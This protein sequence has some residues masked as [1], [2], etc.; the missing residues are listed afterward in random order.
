MNVIEAKKVL[1][2]NFDERSLEEQIAFFK[3]L[4]NVYESNDEPFILEHIHHENFEIKISAL[5]ILE[6]IN[7]EEHISHQSLNSKTH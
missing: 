3:M 7:N 6:F 4:E 5:K 2:N 1:K